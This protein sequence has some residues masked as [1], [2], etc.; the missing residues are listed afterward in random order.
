MYLVLKTVLCHPL[1]DIA[2]MGEVSMLAG[3]R[4]DGLVVLAR[5]GRTRELA[6][7][8]WFCIS[9][10]QTPTRIGALPTRYLCI[11]SAQVAWWHRSSYWVVP[12]IVCSEIDDS[13][14]VCYSPAWV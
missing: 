7:I 13:V 5:S 2:P 9:L 3:K 4:D 11:A 1:R 14:G 10:A 6:L 8:L 12:Y